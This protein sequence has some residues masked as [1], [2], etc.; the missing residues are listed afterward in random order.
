[1]SGVGVVV[2]PAGEPA[3]PLEP[4]LVP[5]DV[6]PPLATVVPPVVRASAGSVVV[7]P[8]AGSLVFEAVVVV[9][10]S[11]GLVAEPA[12]LV[13][14]PVEFGDFLVPPAPL[15]MTGLG[16]A[17][18]EGEVPEVV[19]PVLA[20]PPAESVTRFVEPPLAVDVAV[21]LG[22]KLVPTV[23]AV[24]GRRTAEVLGARGFD[25]GAAPAV[26]A[27]PACVPFPARPAP[28]SVMSGWPAIA[29]S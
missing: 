14:V 10:A 13:A 9:P 27:A 22:A 25:G 11:A 28:G 6:E 5:E 24:A 15:V 1:M 2:P 21:E 20:S 18:G 17:L 23:L 7:P 26:P 29:G 16:F 12:E 8:L 3:E 19:L 4:V